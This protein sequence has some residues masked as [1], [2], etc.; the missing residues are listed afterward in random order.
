MEL[1]GLYI[2]AYLLGSLP[3]AYI[4]GRLVKGIDLRQYGSGNVGSTNV[5]QQMG[6]GWLAPQL[7]FD[8]LG[9]GAAPVWL[10]MYWMGL[11][12]GSWPL[13]GVSLLAVAGHN[14]SPFLKFQGGRGIAVLGGG[15]IG[16]WPPMFAFAALV[17]WGGWAITRASGVWVLIALTLL[18]IA[19]LVA[20]EAASLSWYPVWARVNGDASNLSWYSVVLLGMVVLKRLLSNGTPLPQDM[21]RKQVL[22]NRLFRDRD[23]KDRAQWVSRTPGA[24]E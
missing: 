4:L 23:V 20:G 17:N 24:S 16:V 1:A 21:P 18:P 14:W 2:F 11:E 5:A 9:K 15:L 22:F 19:T 10:G 8:M 7:L 12:A 3:T 6:K 13:L